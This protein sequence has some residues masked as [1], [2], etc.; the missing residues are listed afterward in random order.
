MADNEK[1][2]RPGCCG[3][4]G[5]GELLKFTLAGYVGGLAAGL[6]LDGL[7]HQRSG[8]GQWLV[9][10][11][12]GEGESLLEGAYAASR[13]IKGRA[14]S[15]SEAYGWGK[16]FG[17]AL[18]WVVD[19]ASRL[20]GVDVDGLAGF[21]IPFLYTQT[22]QMGAS[23][24][25]LIH[26]RR[27]GRTWS[28]V[29]GRYLSHPVMVASLGVIVGVPVGLLGARFAGFTP[30]TQFRTAL[31]TIAANLCWLPPLVGWLIERSGRER[32]NHKPQY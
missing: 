29:L 30:S 4:E 14:A 15:L 3:S 2:C 8:L 9:R 32:K 12:A 27:E 31:E 10:T 21:Y 28:A 5:F 19:G 11:L 6:I 20:A 7:G 24:A 1:A 25:G 17:V 23:I 16:L 22:D 13:R 18:P 26:F